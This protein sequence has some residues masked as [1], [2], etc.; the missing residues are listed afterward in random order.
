MF[1]KVNPF[2]RNFNFHVFGQVAGSI[3]MLEGILIVN[4]SIFTLFF[5]VSSK[6]TLVFIAKV[7]LDKCSAYYTS[8]R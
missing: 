7:S 1:T 8:F 2:E 4:Y 3:I 6:I 5:E